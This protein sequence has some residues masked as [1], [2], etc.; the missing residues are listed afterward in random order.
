M[1]LVWLLIFILTGLGLVGQKKLAGHVVDQNQKPV[2]AANVYWKQH[3]QLGVITDYDGKFSIP[4]PSKQDPEQLM[5]SFIGYKTIVIPWDKVKNQEKIIIQLIEDSR[6]LN[7]INVTAKDPISQKYSVVKMERMDVYLSPVASGDPLKA[8]TFLPSS[9]NTDE[10]ANPAIRGSSSDKSRVILNGVPVLKPIRNSQINGMGNFSL[11]NTE[12]IHKQYVYASNPPL[13][14][15]NTSAGLVEIETVRNLDQNLSQVST[16]LAS[17]G[18]FLSQKVKKESLIQLYSNWQFSDAFLHVNKRS[19]DLLKD[20]ESKDAGMNLRLKLNDKLN[21]NSFNYLIDE[22]YDVLDYMYGYQGRSVA[23]NLRLIS[24]TNLLYTTDKGLLSL[25]M[26]VDAAK[27]KYHFGNLFSKGINE[28]VYLSANYKWSSGDKSKFQIGFSEEYKHNRFRD[29]IPHDY[30][31][32]RPKAPNHYQDT[33][34][35][36]HNSEGYA[37][38]NYELS[39]NFNL[40]T[41]ARLNIPTEQQKFYWSGQISI[42]YKLGKDQTFLLSGGRYHNYNTP[43]Y[44]QQ[45]YALNQSYQLALDYDYNREHSS[46]HAALYYKKEHGD[47]KDVNYYNFKDAKI[48]GLE[49]SMD[50]FF[51]RYLHFS[52]SNTLLKQDIKNENEWYAGSQDLDYFIKTSLSFNHPKLFNFSATWIARPGLRYTPLKEAW[53]NQDSNAW[54]PVFS[55]NINSDRYANY[56]NLS[57]NTSRIFQVGKISLIAFASVTNLLDKKN[58]NARQ[59][60]SD[61][62]SSKFKYY[63]QRIYYFGLIWQLKGK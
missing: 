57:V 13:S 35:N 33:S 19:L 59:Y 46:Y 15:G 60:T 3:P 17:M 47:W 6:Q 63:E 50:R 1:R 16:S 20:F 38:W 8:I 25:N 14:Y 2:F 37:Y 40:S 55:E 31:N 5:V 58:Q 62:S 26:G 10:M 18:F 11:F 56:N 24:I 30:Y 51:G 43:N 53:H 9:T 45:D 21:L 32:V 52:L 28:T 42:R 36:N 41:A 23:D 48:V 49:I 7:T 29:S 61:Y 4:L 22:Q 12:I 54:Q 34:L 27:N 39:D 44:Y